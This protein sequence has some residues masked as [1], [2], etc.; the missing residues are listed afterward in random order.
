MSE[1]E[2]RYQRFFLEN[3]IKDEVAT[4]GCLAASETTSKDGESG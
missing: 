2:R 1:R 4:A 3:G